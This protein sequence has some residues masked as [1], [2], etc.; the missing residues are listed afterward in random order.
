MLLKR[1]DRRA[2][3]R[4]AFPAQA[5]NYATAPKRSS[6]P[7]SPAPSHPGNDLTRRTGCC[8]KR[9]TVRTSSSRSQRPESG[10]RTASTNYE[11]LRRRSPPAHTRGVPWLTVAGSYVH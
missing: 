5:F 2:L 9:A 7:M 3:L 8:P 6:Q 11:P 10:L 4:A 1:I